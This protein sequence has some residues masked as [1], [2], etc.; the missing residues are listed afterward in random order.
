MGKHP[1]MVAELEIWKWDGTKL[2]KAKKWDGG[3]QRSGDH[4]SVEREE[5]S[6]A[7]G[8]EINIP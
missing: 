6:Q 1:S 8:G 2:K 5:A 4:A 7:T 3:F